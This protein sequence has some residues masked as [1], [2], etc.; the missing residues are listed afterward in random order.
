MGTPTEVPVPR[1]VKVRDPGIANRERERRPPAPSCPYGPAAGGAAPR[2]I[3][4]NERPRRP[5]DLS[6]Q[7]AGSFDAQTTWYRALTLPRPFSP[8]GEAGVFRRVADKDFCLVAANRPEV[9]DQEQ[10]AECHGGRYGGRPRQGRL[11]A[12]QR[13]L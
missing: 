12:L 8:A 6:W 11:P 5:P 1:K 13:G 9:D 2:S 7:S 4:S 3:V 10:V